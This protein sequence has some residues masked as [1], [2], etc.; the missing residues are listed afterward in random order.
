MPG[1][2]PTTYTPELTYLICERLSAGESLRSVSRDDGMPVM[3][4]IF[5]WMREH[6]EFSNQYD[7]A[8][9]ESA[10]ALVEDMLDIADNQVEQPL[11]VDGLPL[12]IDGKMVMI[13]DMVSVNH[14]KLR[15]DT[16]KWAASKL[17]PKKYGERV[18]IAVNTKELSDM[19][20]EE[21]DRLILER[22]R[23]AQQSAED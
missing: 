8:K 9:M 3:S 23:A 16:R 22:Q 20:E 7:K 4:T 11:L 6:P 15:V 14:A 21:L 12:Q 19:D 13:K 10:D 1:G 17:K 5:K 2:R 18:A